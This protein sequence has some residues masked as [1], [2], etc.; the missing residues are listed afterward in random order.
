MAEDNEKNAKRISVVLL[1][2]NEVHNIEACLKSCSFADE[3]IVV[4]D[5]SSDGTVETARRLGAK[6]FSRSLSGDWAAQKNFGIEQAAGP[7]IFLIDADERVTPDLAK[8]LQEAASGSRCAYFVQRHNAFRHIHATH[9]ILRPDWVCRMVPKTSVKVYGRVHEEIRVNCE[10]KRLGG[11]GLT[12]YP[13]RS[14][15]LYFNKFNTY[16]ELSAEKYLEEG[17][18]VSFVKDIMLRPIW[19]FLKVYFI[20]GGVLDGRAGFIFSINH[21]FYTMNKYV[22]YYFLKYYSG[23]L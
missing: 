14:W 19:A 4:D 15:K 12:H 5:G 9:G 23:E 20:N 22:K 17:R 18:N 21:A 8:Q 2:R 13:Y 3:W 11:T 7:W 16:T 10:K 1:T 6:V